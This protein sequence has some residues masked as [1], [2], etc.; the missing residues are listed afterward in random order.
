[1]ASPGGTRRDFPI[2]VPK[3]QVALLIRPAGNA[4]VSLQKMSREYLKGADYK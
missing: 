3:Y 4:I 2:F 1:M